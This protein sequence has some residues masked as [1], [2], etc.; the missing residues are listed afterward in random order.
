MLSMPRSAPRLSSGALAAE[1][2]GRLGTTLPK[3]E[4]LF[5]RAADQARL[6][7]A[8]SGGSDSMAMLCLAH[9]WVQEGFAPAFC[10]LTVDHGLRAGSAEESLQVAHWCAEMGFQH[11]ILHWEGAK[12]ATGIQAAARA[13]R[14]DL[15][16][17]WCR[18]YGVDVLMTAHTLDDQAET[19][20]MRLRRTDDG[21]KPC[22]Y[23]GGTAMERHPPFPSTP[24]HQA[25]G[26]PPLSRQ[27]QARLD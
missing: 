11:H 25:C 19:V 26:T 13:A 12:P 5:A 8:V 23:L 1:A 22:R 6:A 17:N 4:T 3:P 18:R 9:Q 14:Y 2:A 15:M 24:R 21:C 20:A 10:V 7:L 16:S 27:S